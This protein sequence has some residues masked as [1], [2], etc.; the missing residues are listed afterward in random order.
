MITGIRSV[1]PGSVAPGQGLACLP[2]P[3]W[4]GCG[5]RRCMKSRH[6]GVEDSRLARC[7][8]ARCRCRAKRPVS[9]PMSPATELISP[10]EAV[11]I[12]A[13]SDSLT[14][15]A[16]AVGGS[17]SAELSVVSRGGASED[18]GRGV[19]VDVPTGRGGP[20]VVAAGVCGLNIRI[21]PRNRAM[22]ARNRTMPAITNFLGWRT[23]PCLAC[24]SMTSR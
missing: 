16:L 21:P 24:E 5:I 22:P 1:D 3:S 19:A 20:G 18:V 17:G 7:R 13:V 2:A 23:R 9:A 12:A 4:H 14:L 6:V 11:M 15:G 8:L 10:A